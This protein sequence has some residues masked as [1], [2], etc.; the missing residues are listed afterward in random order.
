LLKVDLLR[1]QQLKIKLIFEQ[2]TLDRLKQ[3]IEQFLCSF[4][5]NFIRLPILIIA[6]HRLDQQVREQAG[7][8]S[9]KSVRY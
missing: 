3:P 5:R 6:I 7:L 1:A 2:G 4:S 8:L 9:Y